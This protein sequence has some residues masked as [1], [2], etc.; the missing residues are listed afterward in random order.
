MREFLWGAV[1]GALA[2]YLY[3]AYGD[4]LHRFKRYIDTNRDWAVEQSD[5]YATGRDKNKK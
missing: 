4:E 2:V 5:G 3:V 1:V